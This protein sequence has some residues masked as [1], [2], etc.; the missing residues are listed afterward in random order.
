M[1]TLSVDPGKI[2]LDRTHRRRYVRGRRDFPVSTCNLQQRK[3]N[4]PSMRKFPFGED[5][6]LFVNT[7]A[8]R[9]R[10]RIFQPGECD[11]FYVE[12]SDL[13]VSAPHVSIHFTLVISHLAHWNA[14]LLNV[15]STMSHLVSPRRTWSNARLFNA[16][17][18]YCVDISSGFRRGTG[19]FAKPEY[20]PYPQV[21]RLTW[22]TLGG[23]CHRRK[24]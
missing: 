23:L 9:F 11:L 21:G 18:S 12:V 1:Q 3:N 19:L 5:I 7:C 4:F 13:V 16:G 24:L 20:R 17:T 6:N 8:S 15:S 22:A 2:K 10:C 14:N